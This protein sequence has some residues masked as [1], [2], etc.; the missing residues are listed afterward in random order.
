MY[1]ILSMDGGGI[2]GIL[3]ARLLSRIETEIPGFSSSADLYAGT[4]TGSILAIGLAKK[5]TPKELVNLYVEN[6]PLIFADD[7]LHRI[8]DLGGLTGAKYT[9]ENRFDG[10]HPTIGDITLSEL[11]PKNVLVTTFQLDSK[12]PIAPAPG[13]RRWKA[14]F[15]HNFP[16]DDGDGG[17]RAI[18]VIMRSSAAPV[19]FPIYQGFIDG[20]VVANNPSMCALAQALHP[21]TGKQDIREVLLLSLGTGT[22]PQFIGAM[23]GDWG[24]KQWGFNLLDL[25]FD[26]GSGLADYQC[27]QLLDG[28]YQRLDVDLPNNIGLDDVNSIEKLTHL[29][30]ACDLAPILA[31]IKDQWMSE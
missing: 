31:W 8:G 28:C 2:R 18:D 3:T 26:S 10:I 11:L 23:D 27:Q 25:M 29:A 16:G 4:S 12:S 9:T 21:K 30:D 17:E 24:L 13:P 5:L 19:Y 6:G 1:R 14:K 7:I 22:K 20:G 15:F